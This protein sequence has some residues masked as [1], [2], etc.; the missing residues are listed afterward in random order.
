MDIYKDRRRENLEKL[1]LK[2]QIDVIDWTHWTHESK[3]KRKKVYDSKQSS[4]LFIID[5]L[6]DIC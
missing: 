3:M 1:Y 4:R 5:Y 2:C 6:F